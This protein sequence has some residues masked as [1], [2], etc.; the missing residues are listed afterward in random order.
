MPGHNRPGMVLDDDTKIHGVWENTFPALNSTANQGTL[1]KWV[2][3]L[4]FFPTL[5]ILK[6]S[7]ALCLLSAK[8]VHMLSQ[9]RPA[10][11]KVTWASA[12]NGEIDSGLGGVNTSFLKIIYKL[13]LNNCFPQLLNSFTMIGNSYVSQRSMTVDS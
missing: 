11:L 6:R 2:H 10:S 5:S 1:F 13:L 8:L 4:V 3:F 12:R 7:L 9:K